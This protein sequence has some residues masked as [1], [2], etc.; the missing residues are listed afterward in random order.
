[1]PPGRIPARANR[2]R[3]ATR[4]RCAAGTAQTAARRCRGEPGW[5]L[6]WRWAW[7]YF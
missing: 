4:A 6:Q 2:C 3:C 7:G 1:M 5:G